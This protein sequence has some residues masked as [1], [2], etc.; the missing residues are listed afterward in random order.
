MTVLIADDHEIFL[1]SL[2]LLISTFS[3][4]TVVG[5]CTSGPAV[6]AFL[7]E[8]PVDLLITDYKM[9]PMT[10]IDLTLHLRQSHP[11][12]RVLMLSVSEEDELMVEAFRAGVWGYVMK[13]AGKDELRRATETIAA[14][15]KYFSE[16]VVSEIIRQTPGESL[17]R[18]EMPL[19]TSVLSEREIEI[20]RLIARELSSNQIAERLFIALRTVETHR[21]NILRKLGVKN[22]AGILKFAI[23][24]GLV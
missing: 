16:S 12:V 23:R 4:V 15:Q 17:L 3:T 18:G 22:T 2:S 11:A 5:H 9:T 6:L 20:V 24:H 13:R 14:G 21:H 1:D 10:G 19:T 8:Q 7:A